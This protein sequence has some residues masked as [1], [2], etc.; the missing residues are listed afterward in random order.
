MCTTMA[1]G[2]ARL[3]KHSAGRRW[4]LVSVWRRCGLRQLLL[5]QLVAHRHAF[6]RR[7][8]QQHAAVT[9][10]GPTPP[11]RGRLSGGDGGEGSMP[12]VVAF[13]IPTFFMCRVRSSAD[14]S[15][16][17]CSASCSRVCSQGMHTVLVQGDTTSEV[18][19]RAGQ[20]WS[21]SSAMQAVLQPAPRSKPGATAYLLTLAI[22]LLRVLCISFCFA[23][24]A[25]CACC[26][27]HIDLQQH[28]TSAGRQ[29]LHHI[30]MKNA[31]LRLLL[32]AIL[33]DDGRSPRQAPLMYWTAAA[34]TQQR[35]RQHHCAV[36]GAES[37]VEAQVPAA[38]LRAA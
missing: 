33:L 37:R 25:V 19:Y 36:L 34:Q 35:Q 30:P 23:A 26:R 24:L 4:R 13:R 3:T 21:C 11:E 28:S 10:I 16:I 6:L 5:Q 18:C 9:R 7:R 1:P 2:V 22:P 20:G 32:R 12:D 29:Q 17:C 15:A 38:A 14:R 27:P 31:A 8:K